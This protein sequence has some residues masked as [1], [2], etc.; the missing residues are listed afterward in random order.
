MNTNEYIWNAELTQGLLKEQRLSLGVEV[1]DILK[2]RKNISYNVWATGQSESRTNT[3]GSYAL[4][5]L[6]YKFNIFGGGK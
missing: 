6:I 5:K 4:F 2:S 3:I 1:I